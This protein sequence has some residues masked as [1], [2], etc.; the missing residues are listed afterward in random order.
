MIVHA[1]GKASPIMQKL[2]RGS[3]YP[4]SRIVVQ[5]EVEGPQ[6]NCVCGEDNWE[7]D[8]WLV[9][10]IIE[11]TTDLLRR[12]EACR[13]SCSRYPAK[14][15]PTAVCIDERMLSELPSW[16]ARCDGRDV[17]GVRWFG[18][19]SIRRYRVADLI[20][21]H[22]VFC[23]F[24]P[25]SVRYQY[26][27][28]YSERNAPQTQARFDTNYDAMNELISQL[29]GSGTARSFI[30]TD[31]EVSCTQQ[32]VRGKINAYSIRDKSSVMDSHAIPVISRNWR[33]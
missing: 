3:C 2:R 23:V 20:V 25:V 17:I 33:K 18:N 10:L 14:R 16:Y 30:E 1:S 9:R 22:P 26:H 29:H 7:E 8:L 24:C 27:G 32:I 13:I 21:S 6:C 12:S 15:H 11:E 28:G 31:G 19:W 4:Q 5:E